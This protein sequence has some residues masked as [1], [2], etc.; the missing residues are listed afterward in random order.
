MDVVLEVTDTFIGDYI[1]A[2]LNP[3]KPPPYDF[4]DLSGNATVAQ[5][6]NG[7]S[8][9]PSTALFQLEPTE[10]AY[11]SAW[12][13]NNIYRQALSLFMLTWI[14]GFIT[15]FLF[16]TLSYFFIFDK[17]T[18]KHPKFLKNQVWL[19][20]KQA[21]T[22][23]PIMT[24]CTVPFF[25][26]EVRGYGKLYDTTA[27][28]PGRWY[29]F[30]QFPIFIVFTDCL[31]YLIHRGL[32]HPWVYKHLHKPHHKWIMP[33]PFASHAFHPLDGFAQSFPYHLFAFVFPL[34]KLSYVFFFLFV[35]FWTILIHDGEYMTNSSVINGAACHTYHHLYFN[36]NYGQYT[37]IWDR[38]GGSYRE[39][40]P[41]M[42]KPDK[43][44]SKEQWEAQVKEMERLVK[45]VEGK[46][47]RT[48]EENGDKKNN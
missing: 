25:L 30:A 2:T 20:I 23:M 18:F 5:S 15:Y 9:K 7:W 13:R 40:S 10:Y 11:M 48:Y 12:P 44:M 26:A 28:G 42:F 47:D 36:Y 39:P 8:Y 34:Q 33:T 29:D 4:P 22:S 24:L 1:Y 37:T 27:D 3:A 45:E 19:E 17:E 43:K 38:L 14:F 6:F 21:N 32:H 35:N 16:A 41:E 46:D 31:I